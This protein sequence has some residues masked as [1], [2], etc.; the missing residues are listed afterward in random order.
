MRQLGGVRD[1][2]VG[3]G[4]RLQAISSR[5]SYVG[6]RPEHGQRLGTGDTRTDRASH[7]S[8]FLPSTPTSFSNYCRLLLTP[9]SWPR[10]AMSPSWTNRTDTSLLIFPQLMLKTTSCALSPR[11]PPYVLESLSPLSGFDQGSCLV[12]LPPGRW[13]LF[14]DLLGRTGDPG[15]LPT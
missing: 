9:R 12:S 10:S 14:G 4:G 1:G 7:T 15:A 3:D 2:T 6:Q 13:S 5:S 8:D 11:T